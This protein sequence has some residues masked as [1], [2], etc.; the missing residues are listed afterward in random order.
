[1]LRAMA[2]VVLGTHFRYTTFTMTSFVWGLAQEARKHIVNATG[3]HS[4]KQFIMDVIPYGILFI[5]AAVIVISNSYI[6]FAQVS[7]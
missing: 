3:A 7:N 4:G 5:T 6:G 1:M 2:H